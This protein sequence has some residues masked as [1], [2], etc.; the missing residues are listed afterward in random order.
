MLTTQTA[1]NCRTDARVIVFV[2]CTLHRSGIDC[3][4]TNKQREE[5][6]REERGERRSS[7][8]VALLPFALVGIVPYYKQTDDFASRRP[9]PTSD[10]DENENDFFDSI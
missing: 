7:F 5:E 9:A 10:D 4:C 8:I 6:R 1:S 3:Y 2:A